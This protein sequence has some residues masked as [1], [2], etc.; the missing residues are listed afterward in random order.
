MSRAVQRTGM[1][2]LGTAAVLQSYMYCTEQQNQRDSEHTRMPPNTPCTGRRW[3]GPYAGSVLSTP[4]CA[5]ILSASD[6][7]QRTPVTVPFGGI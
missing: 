4:F 6:G 1:T 2:V 7:S 3:R 5:A